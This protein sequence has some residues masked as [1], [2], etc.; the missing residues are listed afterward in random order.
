MIIR[1]KLNKIKRRKKRRKSIRKHIQGTAEVPRLS[2]FRSN[3]FIYVQAIDDEKGLTLASLSSFA[4]KEKK[5]NLNK[6]TAELIGSEF[7]KKLKG[8]K[9]SKAVFD[10]GGYIYTGKIRA[11]ADAIRK[12]GV[13]F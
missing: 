11:L 13:Q 8:L 4:F 1:E 2:V 6:K 9:I 5:L 7:G 3:K 12:E 10:R